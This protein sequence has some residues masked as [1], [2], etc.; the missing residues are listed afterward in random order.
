M[1]KLKILLL[2]AIFLVWSSQGFSK[3]L[4]TC[5]EDIEDMYGN[6]MTLIVTFESE[7]NSCLPTNG[8]SNSYAGLFD[9]WGILVFH[10]EPTQSALYSACGIG[11]S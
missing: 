8:Y 2:S 1:R 4:C 9:E 3:K 7:D 5:D 6:M 10:G 11:E